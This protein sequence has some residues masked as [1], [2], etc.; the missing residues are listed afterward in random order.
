MRKIVITFLLFQTF[1]IS[2]AQQSVQTAGASFITS[3]GSVSV[4]IGQ[5][6]F[7]S[8]TNDSFS[9]SQGVQQVWEIFPNSVEGMVKSEVQ[10]SAYPNPVADGLQLTMNSGN[11]ELC[12]WQLFDL[13]GKVLLS[14]NFSELKALV[15]LSALAQSTYILHIYE[16]NQIIQSQKI[17]KK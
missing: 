4:S 12:S 9:I 13:Q 11:S 17:I 7:T 2:N 15:P 14:G 3:N 6:A 10:I 5:L 16:Q 1:S 8:L